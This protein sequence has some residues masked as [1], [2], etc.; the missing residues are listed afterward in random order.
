MNTWDYPGRHSNHKNGRK[1]GGHPDITH[2]RSSEICKPA[3]VGGE[4]YQSRC[5]GNAREGKWGEKDGKQNRDI[6]EKT[7]GHWAP[8]PERKADKGLGEQDG[9]EEGGDGGI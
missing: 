8:N 9:W 7:C 3:S 5:H 4:V 6:F 2:P 1:T